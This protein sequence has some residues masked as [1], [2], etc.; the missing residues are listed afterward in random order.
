MYA[1][2]NPFDNPLSFKNVEFSPL[3]GDV[4]FKPLEV[5]TY[6]TLIKRDRLNFEKGIEYVVFSVVMDAQYVIDKKKSRFISLL[7]KLGIV[8]DLL[9]LPDD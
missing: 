7:S 8:D 4:I 3:E 2:S 6:T 1:T 5:K 9:T